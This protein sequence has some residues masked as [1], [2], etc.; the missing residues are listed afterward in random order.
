MPRSRQHLPYHRLSEADQ[1]LLRLTADIVLRQQF[2]Y[3]PSVRINHR[4]ISDL[5]RSLA[6]NLDTMDALRT[7]GLAAVEKARADL[8]LLSESA[9][10]ILSQIIA[11]TEVP[12]ESTDLRR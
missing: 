5:C 9:R 6:G 12:K 3:D 11:A 2:G 4:V 8:H 7:I 1:L 10:E